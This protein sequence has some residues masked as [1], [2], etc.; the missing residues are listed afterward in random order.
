[1]K[2]SIAREANG[3]YFWVLIQFAAIF[4]RCEIIS[5]YILLL[6]ARFQREWHNC[7]ISH[8]VGPG[9]YSMRIV[10]TYVFGFNHSHF[11]LRATA[12]FN[13]SGCNF[14]AR[15]I[16]FVLSFFEWKI[17]NK[18]KWMNTTLLIKW[19]PLKHA[20]NQDAFNQVLLFGATADFVQLGWH[21]DFTV[22]IGFL[23]EFWI[24]L[25]LEFRFHPNTSFEKSCQKV[26]MVLHC[27]ML[28]ASLPV[29]PNGNGSCW[30]G[31]S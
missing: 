10:H 24:F 6:V 12:T 11:N 8:L 9:F 3:E 15:I 2:C 29:R 16:T 30:V 27:V 7:S 13:R 20:G 1:M 23:M 17:A 31:E 21:Y 14:I 4:R 5:N 18:I 19:N 26:K 28:S 25:A 22:E